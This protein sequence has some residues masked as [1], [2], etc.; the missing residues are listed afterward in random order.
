MTKLRFTGQS[1]DEDSP[2]EP[3]NQGTCRVVMM[4]GFE[5]FNVQLY[6]EVS[7][8]NMTHFLLEMDSAT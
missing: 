3:M 2:R 5:S 7:I 1:D 8:V 4:T 6:K